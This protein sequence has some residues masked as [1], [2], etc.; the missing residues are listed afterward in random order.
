VRS[1]NL[2]VKVTPSM[3]SALAER[4]RDE[5]IYVPEA[6]RIALALWLA[7]PMYPAKQR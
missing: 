1:V 7:Y 6:A 5:G 4:A 3:Y 2:S